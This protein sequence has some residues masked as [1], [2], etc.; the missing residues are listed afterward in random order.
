MSSDNKLY[1]IR[2]FLYEL[3]IPVL[4]E[5]SAGIQQSNH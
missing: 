5:Q 3:F 1:K 4:L 2:K